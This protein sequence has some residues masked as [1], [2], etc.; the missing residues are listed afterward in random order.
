MKVIIVGVALYLLY[1]AIREWW[2]HTTI[3]KT[4]DTFA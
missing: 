4:V 1:V 3:K 2:R